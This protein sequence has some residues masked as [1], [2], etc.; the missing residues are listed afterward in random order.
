MLLLSNI[1][2]YF[3]SFGTQSSAESIH[4]D[5]QMVESQIRSQQQTFVDNSI[6]LSSQLA[7]ILDAPHMVDLNEN[8]T[9]PPTTVSPIRTPQVD[10]SCFTIRNR[11]KFSQISEIDFHIICPIQSFT[12][13]LKFFGNS[14]YYCLNE[15]SVCQLLNISAERWIDLRNVFVEVGIF[16]YK[17]KE[18]LPRD[19]SHIYKYLYYLFKTID[20]VKDCISFV[21]DMHSHN[22]RA[23]RESN[24]VHVQRPALCL[25]GI[26]DNDI[27]RKMRMEN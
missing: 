19:C 22:L 1:S 2:I 4:D 18:K 5:T 13:N 11:L 21:P 8:R 17:A 15:N 23:V 12:I 6:F 7:H 3:Q 16:E 9:S 26:I 10:A 24:F 27:L 25:G 20:L 14:D